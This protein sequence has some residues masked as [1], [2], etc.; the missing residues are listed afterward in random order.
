MRILPSAQTRR[1]TKLLQEHPWSSATPHFLQFSFSF[2][3]S[4]LVLMNIFISE[5][6]LVLV[7]ISFCILG[8]LQE[9][10]LWGFVCD[11]QHYWRKVVFCTLGGK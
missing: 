3:H 10:K 4:A 6:L 11:I 7:F 2:L 5:V 8:Y 1:V 9:E